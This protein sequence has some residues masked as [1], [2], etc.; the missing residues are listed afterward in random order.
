MLSKLIYLQ[1]ID[2]NQ[3]PFRL[4]AI[5]TALESLQIKSNTKIILICTY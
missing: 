3:I 1:N 5:Q 2:C 4:R